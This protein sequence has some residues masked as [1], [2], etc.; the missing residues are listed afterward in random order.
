MAKL[1]VRPTLTDFYEAE[2]LQDGYDFLRL[3][4]GVLAHAS[5]DLHGLNADKFRVNARLPILKQ[6]FD[7]FLEVLIQFV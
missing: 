1:F 6:Q 7:Y 3:E 5:C 2:L 4:Y